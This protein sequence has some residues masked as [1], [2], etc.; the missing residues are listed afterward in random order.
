MKQWKGAVALEAAVRARFARRAGLIGLGAVGYLVVSLALQLAAGLALRAAFPGA[1]LHDPIGLGQSAGLAV[2]LAVTVGSLAIPAGLLAAALRPERTRLGLV[3]PAAGGMALWTPAALGAAMLAN[4][5]AGVLGIGAGHGL[6]L[7]RSGAPLLLAF[8]QVCLVPAVG[9][10]LLFRGVLQGTLRPR[11]GFTAALAAAVPFALLHSRP[12][13]A[14]VALITGLVM[15]LSV[16]A[17]GSL[18]PAI[19]AH[20]GNN[21]LAFAAGWL[22]Q[23]GSPEL[24]GGLQLAA[25]VAFPVWGAMALR[26]A[27]R[28][29]LLPPESAAGPGALLQSPAWLAAM[30]ALGGVFAAR[31]AG[32]F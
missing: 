18:A 8:L 20:L 7:P 32:I 4:L 13:Q 17:T 24:A 10:E 23:Y 25:A 5:L 29:R 30:L 9:E 12:G 1:T 22:L 2:Q 21:A 16:E 27:V 3:R 14:V 31:C 28:R 11:G 6:E 19:A 15:G 26:Q